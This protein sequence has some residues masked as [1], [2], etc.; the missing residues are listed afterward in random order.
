MPAPQITILYN[1]SQ[2][3]TPNTGGA[4]GVSGQWKVLDQVNDKISFQGTGTEDLD[5]N[6][7]KDPFVIPESG[8]QE[9]PRIFV[10]NY[11]EG[12]WDRVWLAG[13]NADQGGGGN[14]RYAFGVYVD[15]TTTSAPILQA[16]DSTAANTKFLEVLGLGSPA[17]SML[18]AIVTTND[19]AGDRWEGTPLAGNSGSYSLVLDS[20]PV[21]LPKM[22]YWNMRL[23][24]PSTATAFSASPVLCIYMTYS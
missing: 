4:S 24:V 10:N 15:G 16:W 22:L 23:L 11:S 7:S 14:Y 12:R 3:D 9:V 18:R 19:L 20:G 8:S 21:T 1:H 13:S 17:N 2:N 5:P 6:S